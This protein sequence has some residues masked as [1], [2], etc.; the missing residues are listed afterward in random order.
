MQS[1][2]NNAPKVMA[3]LT[4][5]E[6]VRFI[7]LSNQISYLEFELAEKYDV[8]KENY[9]LYTI[10]ATMI[11][12]FDKDELIRA[13]DLNQIMMPPN[14]IDFDYMQSLCSR[15]KKRYEEQTNKVMELK[16]EIEI[17]SKKSVT[18]EREAYEYME[19]VDKLK[20]MSMLLGETKYDL[21]ELS[22]KVPIDLRQF[23]REVD[24]L[25]HSLSCAYMER[26]TCF[27]VSAE[28]KRKNPS[29]DSSGAAA[30]SLFAMSGS[31]SPVHKSYAS[32]CL[33]DK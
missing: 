27:E 28:Y 12:N 24:R 10:S 23:Y 1:L 33:F 4:K 32:V 22:R 5:E 7:Q 21:L 20:N 17:L 29:D 2:R 18:T 26:N 6:S 9:R 31:N 25:L 14:T 30:E 13:L 16:S 3:F 8:R 11:P 19:K 15:L